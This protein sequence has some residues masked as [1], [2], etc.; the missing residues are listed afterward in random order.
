VTPDDL[1]PAERE[2]AQV[3]ML[4]SHNGRVAR[5]KYAERMLAPVPTY[6]IQGR[7]VTK[8]RRPTIQPVFK[9]HASYHGS[10]SYAD[11]QRRIRE[12]AR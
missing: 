2:E 12:D 8:P 10:V 4:R 6:D 7:R 3:A 9:C 11:L 5:R 1:T